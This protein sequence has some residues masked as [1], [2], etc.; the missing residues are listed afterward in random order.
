MMDDVAVREVQVKLV[1]YDERTREEFLG[2]DIN[3][4]D[5]NI[6]KYEN[7]GGPYGLRKW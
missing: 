6:C 3:I 2:S 7:N 4:E 1:G 5:R